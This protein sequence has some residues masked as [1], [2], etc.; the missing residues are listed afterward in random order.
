MVSASVRTVIEADE[1]TLPTPSRAAT[2]YVYVVDGVRAV[3]FHV[4]PVGDATSVPLRVTR[5]AA[6]AVS[7]VEAAHASVTVVI[8]ALPK[9]AAG[10]GGAFGS[11]IGGCGGAGG[12]GGAGG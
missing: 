8:V 10:G 5:Y 7:S 12:G 6:T 4:S 1:L 3:S 11:G 2:L 9:T